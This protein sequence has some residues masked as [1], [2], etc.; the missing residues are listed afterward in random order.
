MTA[1]KRRALPLFVTIV[2]ACLVALLIYGISHQSASRTLDEL[3]ARRDYPMAPDASH[4]L[5]WAH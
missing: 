1:V 2:G 3:V 4:R 5:H